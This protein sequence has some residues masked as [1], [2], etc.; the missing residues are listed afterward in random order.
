MKKITT[1]VGLALFCGALSIGNAFAS[2]TTWNFQ[3]SNSGITNSGASWNNNNWGNT[4]SMS[5]GD[6]TLEISAWADSGQTTETRWAGW[7]WQYN[8][9]T[10]NG[11]I[12]SGYITN[13]SGG[14]LSYSQTHTHSS[15]SHAIDNAGYTDMLLFSF[16]EAVSLTSLQLGWI[17]G[18]SDLSIAAFSTMPDFSGQTWA[19]VAISDA[20]SDS[21][22]KN[23]V[24]YNTLDL[25]DNSTVAQYWLIG[26]YNNNFGGHGWS[27]NNDQFKLLALT[28]H[29]IDTTP[30][31]VDV[32]APATAMLF[33]CMAGLLVVRRN[34]R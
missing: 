23:D 18:D 6:M 30:P 29:G 16:S 25:S 33:L 7:P 17:S 4:L 12:E 24:G 9:N 10:P 3:D 14:L 28:T 21:Y 19:D 1:L 32:P 15:D 2:D 20:I 31:P 34:R 13:N 5:S 11:Q 8:T 26:A 27:T 22:S